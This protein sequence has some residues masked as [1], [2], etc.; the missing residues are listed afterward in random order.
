[1]KMTNRE[2]SELSTLAKQRAKLAKDMASYRAADLLADFE[3]QVAR[4]YAWDEEEVWVEAHKIAKDALGEANELI[5]ARCRELG[6]PK[7][8]APGLSYGWYDRRENASKQRRAELRKVAQTRLAAMEKG[9]KVQIDRVCLEVQ[10]FLVSE[11]LD[12]EKARAFL[13]RGMPTV[14]SL[15]PPLAVPEIERLLGRGDE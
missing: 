10:T 1:M 5:A 7:R 2:R 13:E 15:M 8:F 3:A 14:E 9:A 12:S 11:G 6:I 4:E